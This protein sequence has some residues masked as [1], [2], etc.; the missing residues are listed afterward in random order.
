MKAKK[1]A[2]KGNNSR[3]YIQAGKK[4]IVSG[5]NTKKEEWSEKRTENI[6]E[7]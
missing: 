7:N 1:Q 3:K 2:D 4:L 6:G 5:K